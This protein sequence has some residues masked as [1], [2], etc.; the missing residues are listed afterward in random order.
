M[1]NF[2]FARCIWHRVYIN[3]GILL[4]YLLSHFFQ[5]FQ[6]SVCSRWWHV[7]IIQ[8][9]FNNLISWFAWRSRRSTWA[10]STTGA[11]NS[12][13]TCNAL[14]TLQAFRSW[15]RWR[16]D[17][18]AL[19]TLLTWI[20]KGA[21]SARGTLKTINNQQQQDNFIFWM[22]NIKSN[23]NYKLILRYRNCEENKYHI[24]GQTIETFFSWSTLCTHGPCRSGKSTDSRNTWLWR[25]HDDYSTNLSWISMN[26]LAK[27]HCSVLWLG[28]PCI[29]IMCVVNA[30]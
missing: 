6:T 28:P 10:R 2:I 18:L 24:S 20:S 17:Q 14:V 9:S 4:T 12:N 27:F 29:L 13:S 15:A 1:F 21:I 16:N 30:E 22:N 19:F 11:I 26:P 8:W 5:Y 23:W 3:K 7:E 25:K